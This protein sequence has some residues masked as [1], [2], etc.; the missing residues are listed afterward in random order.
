MMRYKDCVD[1]ASSKT[2]NETSKRKNI[3]KKWMGHN[4]IIN[5]RDA[6]IHLILTSSNP[7]HTNPLNTFMKY[8][9]R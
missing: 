8:G 7:S 4:K 1:T 9:V 2:L 3:K 6:P 5:Q